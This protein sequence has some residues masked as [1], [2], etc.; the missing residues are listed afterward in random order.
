MIT[1][2]HHLHG[3]LCEA[4]VI[5]I[6]SNSQIRTLRP[7]EITFLAQGFTECEWQFEPRF[8]GSRAEA[9]PKPLA[10]EVNCQYFWNIAMYF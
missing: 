2:L 4:G 3:A 10:S 7:R 8:S 6:T 5:V 1:S 9:K